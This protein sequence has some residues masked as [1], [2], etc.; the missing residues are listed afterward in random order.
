MTGQNLVI[1]GGWTAWWACKT[2]PTSR[3]RRRL[4]IDE[5]IMM[6][7]LSRL[8]DYATAHDIGVRPHTKT[9]KSIELARRQVE[10]GAIGLT[11]A[12][13]GEAEAMAGHI[14]TC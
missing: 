11:A 7:N 8:A 9:H 3:R 4:V 14:R 12:K 2:Y 5:A 10:L 1:D 6:R 13:V